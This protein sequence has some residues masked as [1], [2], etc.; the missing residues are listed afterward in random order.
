[1]EWHLQLPV[2]HYVHVVSGIAEFATLTRGRGHRHAAHPARR[3]A[4]GPCL[5][6]AW[7]RRCAVG[8]PLLGLVYLTDRLGTLVE[9]IFFIAFSVMVLTEVF[10]PIDRRGAPSWPGAWPSVARRSLRPAGDGHGCR[11]PGRRHG[12]GSRDGAGV[13]D[14]RP[15]HRRLG[16]SAAERAFQHRTPGSA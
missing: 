16:A 11:T 13:T 9:P 5:L 7:S 14:R 3:D 6:R 1:M 10:E 15:D 12:P 2:H 4:R 8:Y